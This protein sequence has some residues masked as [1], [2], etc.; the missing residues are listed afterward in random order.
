MPKKV[1][2]SDPFARSDGAKKP[3]ARTQK[4]GAD[5]KEESG[6]SLTGPGAKKPPLKRVKLLEPSAEPPEAA[7]GEERD[8]KTGIQARQPDEKPAKSSRKTKKAGKQKRS[9]AERPTPR[10][11]KESRV[12]ARAA[13]EY[14][15]PERDSSTQSASELSD[16]GD[17]SGLLGR[18]FETASARKVGRLFGELRLRG[19]SDDVDEF[20]KD[21]VYTERVEPLFEWLYEKYWRVEVEGIENVPDEGGAL[22]VAN[23]SGMLPFDGIMISEAV[24]LESPSGRDVRFLVEDMF[25][26][27]PFLSPF[28]AR[29]G[30][31][32][33]SRQNAERLLQQG[34][35]VCVFPEGEK[36]TGK[37]FTERYQLQRFGRGGFVKLCML[38]KAPLVPVAV[39]GAEE[40]YPI[41]ARLER[42]GKP[43]GLPYVPVTPAW[44][45]LGPLGLIPLPSKWRIRFGKPV[46]FEKYG[47][48]AAKDEILVSRLKEDVRD[49]IQ[50]MIDD[51]LKKRKSAWF[52]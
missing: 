21:P 16:E 31:A 18:L 37:R 5:A 33:A 35:L 28:L 34:N 47:K 24:K 2:G 1:L 42:L 29:I 49:K 13:R 32:R 14:V 39:V 36:G 40:I 51:I 30:A 26:T 10:K 15:T 9:T 27:L 11:K 22:L 4:A 19:R 45:L 17:E 20:G 50:A 6:E 43:F 38:T 52:G 12:D 8:E 44:P 25:S 48:Q 41:I 3:G 23:H 46:R 7:G